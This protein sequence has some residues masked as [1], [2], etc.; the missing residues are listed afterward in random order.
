VG[1]CGE[2]GEL[3]NI[4]KKG[5]FY[6]TKEMAREDVLD[7]L[8]DVLYYVYAVAHCVGLDMSYVALCNQVKL[9]ERG[10]DDK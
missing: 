8:G 3:A 2:V 1:L 6:P 9:K 10:K 7:E 4:Y 5:R